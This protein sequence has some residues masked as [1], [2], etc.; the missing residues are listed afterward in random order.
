VIGGGLGTDV[1]EA[2]HRHASMW[3]WATGMVLRQSGLPERIPDWMGNLVRL[4]LLGCA[5]RAALQRCRKMSRRQPQIDE[6]CRFP[7]FEPIDG[8]GT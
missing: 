1:Q 4:R 2:K 3:E 7:I 6:K 5:I 8:V